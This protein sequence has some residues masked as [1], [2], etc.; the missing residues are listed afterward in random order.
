[1]F[2]P[3]KEQLEYISTT[4]QEI[5]DDPTPNAFAR[6]WVVWAELHLAS[7]Q[8]PDKR[9]V[10]TR[11]MPMVAAGVRLSGKTPE[12]V[13]EIIHQSVLKILFQAKVKGRSD[14][15]LDDGRKAAVYI[16]HH[17]SEQSPPA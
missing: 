7:M 4:L 5:L 12:Q 10:T 13:Q 3:S 1:M 15:N 17:C 11:I 2:Q 9:M 8:H 14:L 16:R 6:T